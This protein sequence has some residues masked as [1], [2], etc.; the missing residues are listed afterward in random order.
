MPYVIHPLIL[1]SALRPRDPRPGVH[2][3]LIEG[4]VISYF[5]IGN[6]HKIL[7]DTGGQAPDGVRWM[8]YFRKPEQNPLDQLALYDTRPEE[9]DTVILTHLHWDHA[10]NNMLY[11]NATFYVQRKEY[12]EFI[13]NAD[14]TCYDKASTAPTNYQFLDGDVELFPGIKLMLM[15]GH[16]AGFQ[17]VIVETE[18]Q[19]H[20]ILSDT[21][22]RLEH[23]EGPNRL[24]QDPGYDTPR[25]TKCIALLDSMNAVLLPGHDMDVFHHLTYPV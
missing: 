23:W 3:E 2:P 9:I 8:P 4:P 25:L 18:K 15:P 20:V 10:G 14:K 1:G 22:V 13:Q 5:L 16:T 11:P 24:V 19:P 6:G 7:V 17:C 21:A 12:E